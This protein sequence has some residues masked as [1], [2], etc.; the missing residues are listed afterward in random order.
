MKKNKILKSI[1]LQQ[2]HF[3]RYEIIK[4]ENVPDRSRGNGRG[5]VDPIDVGVIGIRAVATF[6]RSAIKSMVAS[7]ANAD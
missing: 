1:K 4:V 7:L 2:M 6:R 5:Q 3:L